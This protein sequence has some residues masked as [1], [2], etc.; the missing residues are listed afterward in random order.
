MKLLLCWCLVSLSGTLLALMLIRN[1]KSHPDR[2]RLDEAP[3]AVAPPPTPP[4][5]SNIARRQIEHL[6]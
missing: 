5:A 3:S 4:Q 2:E 1:G 6:R